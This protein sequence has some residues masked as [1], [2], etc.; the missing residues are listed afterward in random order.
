MSEQINDGA[1][2][3]AAGAAEAMQVDD[4]IAS[5]STLGCID[6]DYISQPLYRYDPGPAADPIFNFDPDP[7]PVSSFH[8]RAHDQNIIKMEAFAGLIRYWNTRSEVTL[9]GQMDFRL[10]RPGPLERTPAQRWFPAKL[11]IH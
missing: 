6:I 4:V 7:I 1:S 2:T 3:P 10:A 8:S 5:T 9:R 11:K